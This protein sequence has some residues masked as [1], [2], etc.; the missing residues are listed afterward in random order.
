MKKYNLYLVLLLM[1]VL[2]FSCGKEDV[3][4]PVSFD[5]EANYTIAEL[6]ALRTSAE[7]DS[8]PAADSIII[9]GTVISSDKDGNCHKYLMIQD[10]TGG[11][12]IQI[13]NSTLYMRYPVGQ[14]LFVKCTGLALSD[15]NGLYQL[16]WIFDGATERIPPDKEGV[17]LYRDGI[18]GQEPAPAILYSKNDIESFHYNTLVKFEN[19]SFVTPGETY[20]DSSTGYTTT[21][22][23]LVMGDGTEVTLR[24]SKYASF[25][26]NLMP[27]GTGSIVGILTAFRDQAQLTIRSLDDVTNFTTVPVEEEVTVTTVNLATNPLD[28]GW[29]NHQVSGSK[30]WDYNNQ[31]L[32]IRGA[33]GE[34]NDVWL[35]S[36]A[37]PELSSYQNVKLALTHRAL[38]GMGNNSNMK[39]YYSTASPS[40]T[41][42]ASEWTEIQTTASDYPSGYEDRTFDLPD[43]AVSN[44]NFRIAFRY[45]DNMTT[46]WIISGIT[47]KSIISK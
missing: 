22:R 33:D 7:Y 15:Y 46:T 42:N 30:L 21:S 36:P 40:P 11:I 45:N 17:F 16:N 47:F 26:N 3:P 31:L 35:I 37:I 44:P 43:H 19:C 23:Y 2:I 32:S 13:N 27:E 12:Q 5:G 1:G 34:S 39:I 9:S 14:K 29:R 28:N 6:I 4:P 24:T 8:L 10:E 41:F 38:N 20:F 18:I 25:A